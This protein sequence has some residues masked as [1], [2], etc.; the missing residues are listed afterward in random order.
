[1]S[2][3]LQ[4]FNKIL[5]KSIDDAK[6]LEKTHP[7][8][9]YPLW[10][11]ICDYIIAFAKSK[12]CPENMKRSMIQQATQIMNR[13]KSL[14]IDFQSPQTQPSSSNVELPPTASLTDT[15]KK[16]DSSS[17]VGQGNLSEADFLALPNVP[18]DIPTSDNVQKSDHTSPSLPFPP[19]SNQ[20]NPFGSSSSP[21]SIP[22][23]QNA[24]TSQRQ[25]QFDLAHLEEEL[26]KMPGN[27][28]EITPKG[29]GNQPL[30][31]S[32]LNPNELNQFKDN[33][34]T[35]D[36]TR[37]EVGKDISHNDNITN[38]KPSPNQKPEFHVA[39]TIPFNNPPTP[40]TSDI[41][42]EENSVRTCF[43]CGA[44]LG[45]SDRVCPQCGANL[46]Q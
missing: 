33:L 14:Q 8:K 44:T 32:S 26:K 25:D 23:P 18:K 20:K 30:I 9:A 43:A 42:G 29:F 46:E 4:K 11:K 31:P 36:I 37:V 15:L 38:L 19:S 22:P 7:S 28:K 13:A 45:P 17:D 39:G 12:N 35:L 34:T 6:V 3:E 10:L 41:K 2:V 1:M 24:P 27:L 16:K 5:K 21:A 40:P